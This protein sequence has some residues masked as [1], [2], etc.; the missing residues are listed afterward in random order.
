MPKPGYTSLTV[1]NKTYLKLSK[2]AKKQ[3]LSKQECIDAWLEGT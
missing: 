1:K 3:K 2:M